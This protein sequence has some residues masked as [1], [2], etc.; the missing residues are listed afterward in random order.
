VHMVVS[1]F[2]KGSK[3]GGDLL[4]TSLARSYVKVI[5]A[6]T[7]AEYDAYI[8]NDEPLARRF[9]NLSINEVSHSVTKEILYSWLETY[10]EQ[11]KDID[12]TILDKI[13]KSNELYRPQFAEPAKSIDILESAVAISNVENKKIDINIINR[14]FKEQ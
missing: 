6:T 12:E 5:A 9:K 14:I 4:K 3:L 11:N 13:I 8:A 2:G 7:R 1:I 10:S